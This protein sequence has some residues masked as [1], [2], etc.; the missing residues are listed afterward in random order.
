MI[1]KKRNS[2]FLDFKKTFIQLDQKVKDALKSL[3]YS[4]SRLCIVVDKKIH[5]RGY[6]MMATL[7]EHY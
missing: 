3:N 5:L 6:L 2:P 1:S 7:E 4:R